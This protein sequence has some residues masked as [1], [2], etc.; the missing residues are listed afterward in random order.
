MQQPVCL[1]R[2]SAGCKSKI[3]A[4]QIE[5][6]GKSCSSR[7]VF[8][9]M[10]RTGGATPHSSFSVVTD[11]QESSPSFLSHLLEAL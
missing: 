9:L 11:P 2:G 10:G 5:S 4:Q 8:I 1:A 6:L 3:R 7:T